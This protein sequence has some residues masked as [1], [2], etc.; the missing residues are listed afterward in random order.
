LE[1][2]LPPLPRAGEA[3]TRGEGLHYAGSV[4]PPSPWLLSPVG[5]REDST[6]V[7]AGGLALYLI[8]ALACCC[9]PRPR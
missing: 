6:E 3:F 1:P 4:P 7:L 2:F 8:W 9:T 5:A